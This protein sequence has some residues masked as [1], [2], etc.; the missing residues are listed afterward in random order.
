MKISIAYANT[1]SQSWQN[2]TVDE[3]TTVKDAIEKSGFLELFPLIN[4]DK[5][6]VGIFGKLT[7]LTTQVKDGDR[8]EI[9]QPIIRK[10]DEDEDED[11]D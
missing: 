2:L 4:L 10:L 6:K 7:K 8:I 9:Y 1:E 5:D 3:G 11:D